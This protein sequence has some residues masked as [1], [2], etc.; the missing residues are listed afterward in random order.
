MNVTQALDLARILLAGRTLTSVE[1]EEVSEDVYRLRITDNFL[2]LKSFRKLVEIAD[3]FKQELNLDNDYFFM[4]T[5]G[6]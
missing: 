1:I 6:S 5:A 3:T 4:E 2:N